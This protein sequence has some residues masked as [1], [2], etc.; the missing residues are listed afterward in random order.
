MDFDTLI[1]GKEGPLATIMLNRPDAMNILDL[2]FIADLSAAITEVETDDNI[3]AVIIWG[4]P[5]IFAAGGDLKLLA[6]ADQFEMEVFVTRSNDNYDRIAASHKPYVA[7]MAG[8]TLGGGLELALACD[9]RIAAD[10]AILG[11]PETNNAI[12]PGAGGTQRLP[13]V[14]GWG[15]ARHMLLTGEKIDVQTAFAI[16][17]VTKVVPAAELLDTARKMASNLAAKSPLAIRAAKK[18]LT[19]SESLLLP[20]GLDYE[21]K[22]WA[23]LFA[24]ADHSE[25]MKVLRWID[26]KQGLSPSY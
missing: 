5:K 10:T 13:R 25:G 19:N 21:Q 24:N 8:L 20:T 14:V 6:E 12:I 17:L 3:K 9:V 11:L 15:W 23:L 7:A 18:C 22:A 16:G 1:L 26:L 4:G 2:Q